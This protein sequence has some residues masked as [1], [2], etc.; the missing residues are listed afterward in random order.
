M[1]LNLNHVSRFIWQNT[2]ART[3]CERFSV[4]LKRCALQRQKVILIAILFCCIS[5]LL[6]AF[7]WSAASKKPEI[8][9]AGKLQPFDPFGM[10]AAQEYCGEQMAE[11]LGG[12]LLRYYVDD[13]AS[14]LD[15]VNG[16]YRVYLNADVGNLYHYD[17]IVVHCFV[18]QWQAELDYYR[19]INPAVKSMRSSDLKFFSS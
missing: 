14:R 6:G 2:Y 3:V 7:N 13:R 8:V 10:I 15:T 19:E 5:S 9:D 1:N 4:I 18:D 16:I 12:N 17:E 11:R